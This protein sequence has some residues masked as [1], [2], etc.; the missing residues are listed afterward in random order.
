M[1]RNNLKC[2]FLLCRLL[3]KLQL[4]GKL[5]PERL[6]KHTVRMWQQSWWVHIQNLLML[7]WNNRKVYFS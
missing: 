3:F 4:E 2:Y 5:L 1:K 7:L 6:W